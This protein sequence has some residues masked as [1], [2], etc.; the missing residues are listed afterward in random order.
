MIISC[1]QKE[2]KQPDFSKNELKASIRTAF[3]DKNLNALLDQKIKEKKSIR[4]ET[5]FKLVDTI[6]INN[7][8]CYINPRSKESDTNP[9]AFYTFKVMIKNAG[10]DITMVTIQNE[11][12]PSSFKTKFGSDLHYEYKDDHWKL[13]KQESYLN[14]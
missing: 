5:E 10:I 9:D 1:T 4:I 8:I 3:R 6:S 7:K 11:V 14:D 13:V 2:I 12:P